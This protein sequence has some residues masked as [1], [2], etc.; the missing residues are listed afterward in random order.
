MKRVVSFL[1]LGVMLCG[2]SGN[3]LM[4]RALAFRSQLLSASHCSFS[5]EITADYGDQIHTFDMDC[6]SD[7][8][9]KLTFQ[10]TAPETIRGISGRIGDSGGKLTF[11]DT[12]LHFDLLADRQLSPISAPWIMVKTLRSGYLTS[13]GEENG[14][15]RLTLNDS[16]MEDAL[17]VDV[18]ISEKDQP[19]QCEILYSGKKILS[20]SVK[21]FD[22][23]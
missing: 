6:A 19:F 13:V 14:M 8:E 11:D 3:D 23:M 5:A 7:A 16:Y 12:A 20:L 4:E 18:W 9:G 22:L 1:L 21:N 10:V 15:L 17:Q 2:C